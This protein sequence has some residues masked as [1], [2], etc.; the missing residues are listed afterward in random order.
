VSCLERFV[1][2]VIGLESQTVYR[3]HRRWLCGCNLNALLSGCPEILNAL[4]S[5]A[6]TGVIP[7][8]S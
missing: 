6:V 5:T 7:C 8:G 2:D 4:L 3:A 1:V